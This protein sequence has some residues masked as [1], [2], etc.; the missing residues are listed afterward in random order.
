MD[1]EGVFSGGIPRPSPT[2]TPV[3]GWGNSVNNGCC[4]NGNKNFFAPLPPPKLS[5][6]MGLNVPFDNGRLQRGFPCFS[7]DIV[8]PKGTHKQCFKPYPGGPTI[9]C[10]CLFDSIW[11]NP[12]GSIKPPIPPKQPPKLPNPPNFV[13]ECLNLID[14]AKMCPVCMLSEQCTEE[15]W[16]T[17]RLECCNKARKM[18]NPSNPCYPCLNIENWQKCMDSYCV[19][20]EESSECERLQQLYREGLLSLDGICDCCHA[21][22]FCYTEW[23]LYSCHIYVLNHPGIDPSSL[24][25]LFHCA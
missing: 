21:C 11:R 8:C 9:C 5:G 20:L 17:N 15:E 1:G 18:G 4:G 3:G 16:K 19:A 2:T 12:P 23:S 6:P 7:P 13:Y 22:G 14:V 24:N 10:F 25:A